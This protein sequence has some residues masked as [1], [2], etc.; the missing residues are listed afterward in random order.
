[1][2]VSINQP[3]YLPW[4]GYFHRI[5]ISDQHVI[6]DH[7][8]F[9]KNSMTN[10]NKIRTSQDW[11]WLT[12]PVETKGKFG[13]LAINQLKIS[14]NTN[15]RKKHWQTLQ[16][17]YGRAPFFSKYANFF[18][19]VYAKEWQSLYEL[20]M[21]IVSFFIK[22]FGIKTP[23]RTSSE[24]NVEG[25]KSELV[26]NI[27]LE[28]G[29][30]T[31][32]SGQLGKNYLS[33]KDFSEAGI[34][35]IYHDFSPPTYKQMFPGFESNMSAVDVLFNCGEEHIKDLLQEIKIFKDQQ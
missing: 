19:N 6:L 14:E 21:E 25:K 10:R 9:E 5:A 26:L 17:N 18:E 30:S 23:L 31:Y 16:Q 34:E 3:A 29:A 13:D 35:V 12:V 22:T 24:I 33:E 1:M 2:K 32:I 28:L 8:Q 15:W 7:V 27:C 4:L 11:C 20:N